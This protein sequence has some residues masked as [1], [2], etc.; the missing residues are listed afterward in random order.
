MIDS[1]S[2]FKAPFE[3]FSEGDKFILKRSNGEVYFLE[4]NLGFDCLKRQTSDFIGSNGV[5]AYSI[6][7]VAEAK[8]HKYLIAAT[9][10]KFVGKILSS[11]IF[12]IEEVK[13]IF[14]FTF[15]FLLFFL[16]LMIL[17][18]SKKLVC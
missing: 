5:K 7:G 12:K 15:V 18:Y 16:E 10:T 6:V 3:I 8:T 1:D 11:N 14:N 9:K 13:E 17:I 2:I 4:K